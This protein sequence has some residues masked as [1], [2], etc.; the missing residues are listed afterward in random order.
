MGRRRHISCSMRKIQ[1]LPRCSFENGLKQSDP[2]P[3]L[4]PE[5]QLSVI[6]PMQKEP[7]SI[8]PSLLTLQPLRTEGH[9]VIL[10]DR[11]SRD[12]SVELAR[13]LVDQVV[14]GS[15]MRARQMNLGAQHAWGDTL[16][17][18]HAGCLLPEQ[19]GKLIFS[20]LESG[21][22]QWGCFDIR[23][24][25]HQPFLRIV[26]RAMSW[27]SRL[28]GVAA[29]RQGMFIRR[30]LFEQVGG[31][32]DIPLQEDVF[33]CKQLKQIGRPV[34]LRPPVVTS[35]R[36]PDQYRVVATALN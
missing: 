16:L 10:V 26:E 34:F 27:R 18:L 23:L 6:V 31:F 2:H 29:G 7:A 9:E 5:Q 14:E 32:P 15:R 8:I 20:A 30:T 4:E 12:D 1:V 21:K 22:Y 24:S 35:S 28:T 13:E 19:A 36:Q 11:G 33:M 17:F 3:F 25:G